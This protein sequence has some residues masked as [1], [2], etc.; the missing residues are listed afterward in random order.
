M[1]SGRSLPTSEPKPSPSQRFGQRFTAVTP[2]FNAVP[3]VLAWPLHPPIEDRMT[4]VPSDGTL[5][6]MDHFSQHAKPY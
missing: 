4:R 3:Y 1:W 6:R 5:E 2:G